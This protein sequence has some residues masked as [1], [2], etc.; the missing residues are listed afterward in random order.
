MTLVTLINHQ[1]QIYVS[2]SCKLPKPWD[3][4]LSY[5]QIKPKKKTTINGW[6]FLWNLL[7]RWDLLWNFQECWSLTTPAFLLHIGSI[8]EYLWYSSEHIR[9]LT[10][11]EALPLRTALA[12]GFE[13]R[14]SW[15]I[16]EVSIS[17]SCLRHLTLLRPKVGRG[18]C[19]NREFLEKRCWLLFWK[20][21]TLYIGYIVHLKKHPM[22]P[23]VIKHGN[24][25]SPWNGGFN[26]K[27]T[28][29]WS[30]FHCHVWLIIGGYPI[31]WD[32][33]FWSSF[34]SSCWLSGRG[35]TPTPGPKVRMNPW[36]NF[37][38]PL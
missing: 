20:F 2:E 33:E 19:Q 12:F 4:G 17:L 36:Q 7:L 37:L 11:C 31:V 38:R 16:H 30:I 24:G 8:C 5:F 3:F 14:I 1:H 10:S 18:G 13:P 9:N 29:K 35:T 34:T 23:L 6:I 25:K 15:S 26:R 21:N 28:D 27:L 22:Y 32:K